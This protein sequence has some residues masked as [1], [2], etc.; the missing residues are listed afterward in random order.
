M[1]DYEIKTSAYLIDCQSFLTFMSFLERENLKLASVEIKQ[2]VVGWVLR[3]SDI[4]SFF[5][6]IFIGFQRNG[7][8]PDVFLSWIVSVFSVVFCYFTLTLSVALWCYVHN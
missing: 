4:I 5:S 2:A 6:F 7:Q 3:C 8:P 1:E